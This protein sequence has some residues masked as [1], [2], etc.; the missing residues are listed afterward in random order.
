MDWTDRHR[1]K[2][3][4]W[5]EAFIWLHGLSTFQSHCNCFSRYQSLQIPKILVVKK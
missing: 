2:V 3:G 5:R 1:I 4:G